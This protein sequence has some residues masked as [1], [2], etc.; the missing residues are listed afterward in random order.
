MSPEY[1]R[2]G[3]CL[4]VYSVSS[5]VLFICPRRARIYVVQHSSFVM[6][7][8]SVISVRSVCDYLRERISVHV[9]PDDVLGVLAHHP[10]GYAQGYG[11][12]GYVVRH[13]RVGTY[14]HV[15]TNRDVGD[16]LSAGVDYH[17]VAY[18]LW[19]PLAPGA[20]YCYALEDGAV[21]SD[22]GVAVY[23]DAGEVCEVESSAYLRPE[24]QLYARQILVVLDLSDTK[25]S[26]DDGFDCLCVPFG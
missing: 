8:I 18:P 16:D 2:N 1:S 21:V 5:V 23:Y 7:L 22:D 9:V 24:P 20:A 4:S 17:V 12:A 13:H 14:H 19:H 15:V 11:V 10:G 26:L 3:T 6:T 25:F